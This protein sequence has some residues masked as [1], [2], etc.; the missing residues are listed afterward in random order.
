M[1]PLKATILILA[2]AGASTLT[3]LLAGS[4][5]ADQDHQYNNET[6]H[7][8]IHHAM[9]T[10]LAHAGAWQKAYV[11]YTYVQQIIDQYDIRCV[12]GYRELR[13]RYGLCLDDTRI[14]SNRSNSP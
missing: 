6:E 13:K 11:E 4:A 8:A 5:R 1:H 9:A 10:S 7:A 12:K 14:A 2:L 3:L